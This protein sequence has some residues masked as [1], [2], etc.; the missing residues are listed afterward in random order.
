M[1]LKNNIVLTYGEEKFLINEF[2]EGII[3]SYLNLNYL[4][5]NLTKIDNELIDFNT[6]INSLDTLPLFDKYRI[7]IINNI[8]LS[9]KGI[10]KNKDF[11]DS[12][13]DYSNK[14]PEY[15][16]LIINSPINNIYKGK[17]FKKISSI[18]EVK[19][20]KKLDNK[21]LLRYLQDYFDFKNIKYSK[22]ILDFTIDKSSYFNK[23]L[24]KNLYDLNNELNKINSNINL[25]KNY[26]DKIFTNSL[27]SNIFKLTDAILCRDLTLSINLFYQINKS[28][29][30]PF[31]IFYMI[32]RLIRNILYIKECLRLKKKDNEIIQIL[33]ISPYELKKIKPIV[34][35]WLYGNLKNSIHLAYK[36]EY[37]L[38]TTNFNP[39]ILVE[40]YI[41]DILN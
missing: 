21:E 24:N 18:G 31:R 19:E 23:E 15:S 35:K 26:I 10:S 20:F 3:N 12:L 40:N 36:T 11:L 38:K 4:D 25:T 17:F 39:T 32:L 41:L 5:F 8:D 1:K 16:I 30:D 2:N 22:E 37:M 7:T 14:I 6:V 28:I 33:S 13:L 9:K 34:S 27:E 29:N